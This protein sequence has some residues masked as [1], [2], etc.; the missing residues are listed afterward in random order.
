MG[1]PR[2]LYRQWGTTHYLNESQDT[3]L[4]F[5]AQRLFEEEAAHGSRQLRESLNSLFAHWERRHGFQS[6]AAQILLPA[7]YNP[8]AA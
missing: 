1:Q 5:Q 3:G 2:D 8:E 7:G 4:G 6:G